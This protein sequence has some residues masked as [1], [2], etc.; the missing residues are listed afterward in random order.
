MRF[1]PVRFAPVR[2]ALVRFAMV[3]TAPVRFALVRFAL[4]RLTPERFAPVRSAPWQFGAQE[5][6]WFACFRALGGA[7][8]RAPL[9]FAPRR[10]ACRSFAPRKSAPR[11]SAPRKSA[12]RRSAFVNFAFLRLPWCSTVQR[13]TTPR[14]SAPGFSVQVFAPVPM[15][16][17]CC[18]ARATGA[19]T[20]RPAA[21]R[22]VRVIGRMG[23]LLSC[24]ARGGSLAVGCCLP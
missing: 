14:Q 1:A 4:V 10:S 7:S 18:A 8:N 16:M 15:V 12:P 3:R 20:A 2:F 9:S 17:D 6:V 22:A 19:A 21:A 24:G 13:C 5:G 11:R 23:S